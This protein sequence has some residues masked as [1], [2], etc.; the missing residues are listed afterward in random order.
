MR[1]NS[2]DIRIIGNFNSESEYS[3]P[4]SGDKKTILSTTGRGYFIV[5]ILGVGQEP[6]NH[7]LKDIEIKKDEFEKWGRKIVL[8]FTDEESYKKFDK[9]D[10]P[11][12]PSTICFGIDTNGNIRKQ[13]AEAMKLKN[14]GH[15]PIFIIGDTFNRVVFESDGYTIGLG[16]QLIHTIKG[17]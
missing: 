6:T 7:A 3:D 13:I 17:L 11:N 14:N 1:D 2:E 12:L 8:L 9:D 5:G 15:L 10:F 16:E 4:Q